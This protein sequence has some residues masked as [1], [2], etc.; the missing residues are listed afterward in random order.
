[1]TKCLVVITSF[2]KADEF[3]MEICQKKTKTYI[4][5]R[6]LIFIRTISSAYNFHR[7]FGS[8]ENFTL[9]Q[10]FFCRS[11]AWRSHF[12]DSHLVDHGPRGEILICLFR[13]ILI[14]EQEIL[15]AFPHLIATPTTA[16]CNLYSTLCQ[17]K[18]IAYVREHRRCQS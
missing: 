1:M 18:Y 6:G 14:P 4:H 15:A 10:H 11:T 17:N 3:T 13:L 12:N 2:A 9:Q 16:H 5:V 7:A 8:M